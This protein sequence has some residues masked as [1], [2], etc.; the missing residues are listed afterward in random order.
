MKSGSY[1]IL[2]GKGEFK[3]RI[4]IRRLKGGHFIQDQIFKSTIMSCFFNKPRLE[5]L[6]LCRDTG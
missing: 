6:Q 1:L 3:L 5:G 4:S 2:Y